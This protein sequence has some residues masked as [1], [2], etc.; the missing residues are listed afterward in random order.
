MYF[1]RDK[2]GRVSL[3][4]YDPKLKQSVFLPRAESKDLDKLTDEEI[5]VWIDSRNSTDLAWYLHDPLYVHFKRWL[6]YSATR[7]LDAQTISQHKSALERFVFEFFGNVVKK[8]NPKDWPAYC[9]QFYNWMVEEMQ[10]T[11]QQLRVANMA[12]RKFYTWMG[13][14]NIVAPV[15]LA[16]R[17]PIMP[18]VGTK[19]PRPVM[20]EE[21]LEWAR[22]CEDV[23][24][25]Y[26]GLVGYFMSLRPQESFASRQCDF[27]AGSQIQDLECT[28]AMLSAELFGG[29][30]IY[31]AKQKQNAGTTTDKAKKDSKGWVSCF[32]R[33]AAIMI[34]SIAKSFESETVIA[35]WN[36]R[37]LYAMW[38]E[39]GV[40]GLT[41][42]DLRRASIYYLG[43]HTNVQP[44]QLMK[45]ARHKD[46]KTTM[47]YCRQPDKGLFGDSGTLDLES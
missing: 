10:H 2:R 1:S 38:A 41:L 33:D 28:K 32:N 39:K 5:Q 46:L 26:L 7:G 35:K 44:L 22:N 17:T 25:R 31:V 6:H 21:V 14:E 18:D 42:K 16:L 45:H 3:R 4:E 12:F 40:K 15:E 11:P 43:H 23:H 27:R 34:V 47:L 19:L 30:A 9:G 37:K 13:E 24:I 36:N 20:P 8:K 29:L